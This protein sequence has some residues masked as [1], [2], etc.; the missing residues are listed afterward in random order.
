MLA[1]EAGAV[2]FGP[3]AVLNGLK[4]FIKGDVAMDIP[5]GA[6]VAFGAIDLPEGKTLA[7]TGVLKLGSLKVGTDKTALTAEQL[8]QITYEG[9]KGKI[10][11]SDDITCGSKV[12][13]LVRL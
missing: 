10:Y 1:I 7:L 3:K 13:H 9:K 6:K 8:A 2:N 5:A 12:I 11:V 4:L